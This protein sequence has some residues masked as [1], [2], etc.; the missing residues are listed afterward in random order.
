LEY[1]KAM[2]G[3]AAAN[4]LF[5]WMLPLAGLPILFHLFLRVRKQVRPFPS[6][7][8]FLQ[9]QPRLSARKRIREWL[10]LLLRML[11]IAFLMLALSRPV[12]LGLNGG[13]PVSQVIVIDN[14]GSMSGKAPDG[15]SKLA[16]ALDAAAGLIGDMEKS[17]SL[18]LVLLV[19][20]PVT[21]VPDGLSADRRILRASLERIK[22]THG[23]GMPAR[24]LS[25]AFS[26]LGSAST[27]RREIHIF[28]DMQ[29]TEW[30]RQVQDPR[31]PPAGVSITVH[32]IK[33]EPFD[34]ANVSVDGIEL[35]HCVLVADRHYLANVTL[36][37]AS[38]EAAKVRLNSMDQSGL[39]N[40]LPVDVAPHSS[41][42]VAVPFETHD[43][44][45]EWIAVNIENDAFEPDNY[46]CVAFTCQPRRKVL[47]CG[48]DSAFGVVPLAVSP[49][50]DGILSGLIPVFKPPNVSLAEALKDNPAMAVL[51][52]SGVVSSKGGQAFLKSYLEQGGNVLL[53]P[54]S[55]SGANQKE[56]APPWI[57]VRFGKT[58]SDGTGLPIV[59]LNK[60]AALW[61]DLRDEA[62]E[63]MLR[64]VR[65]FKATALE[66]DA[67]C[68][69]LLALKDGTAILIEQTVGK[70]CI[71]VSG[72]DFDPKASTLP[73]KA[74]F[75]AL[76]HG[77]ALSGSDQAGN[78][79]AIVAG[80][81]PT[82]F[83]GADQP[84]HIH[85]VTG[86]VLEW[87]GLGR[88][89][90]VLPRAGIYSLESSNSISCIA[91]RS[92]VEEGRESFLDTKTVPALADLRHNVNEYKDSESVV[93]FVRRMRNG[94]DLYLPFLLLAIAA[95]LAEGL[96][97]NPAAMK[98]QGK[99][100][101]P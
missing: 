22:E 79:A 77:M 55:G 60:Q 34:G 37:N 87:Q 29:E 88:D 20:D 57:H 5:L 74:G 97:V 30:G 13:G 12:F 33:S 31:T 28:T 84:F 96:I 24:A 100:M 7:M 32:R 19:D 36:R 56:Q 17:D 26:L 93:R 25:Q 6:L 11:L 40:A 81:K 52:W 50:G 51:K 2:F 4:P 42:T 92:S 18:A 85:A 53:L 58:I 46:S 73:L 91:V 75:V 49:S 59:A 62:G 41:R 1:E 89:I 39:K 76:V 65:A 67:G 45:A 94:V 21:A 80:T 101:I 70:G 68:I 16:N 63:V 95:A 47:F 82:G 38:K 86:G 8:F 14:S 27:A 15:R 9:A 35:P 69:S 43:A 66:P 72:V 83:E 71:F 23:S 99:G 78:A 98:F 90:P 48:S 54:D 10:A 61:D 44:L 3:I 64:Q